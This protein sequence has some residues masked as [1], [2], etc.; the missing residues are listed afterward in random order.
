[1]GALPVRLDRQFWLRTPE[2]IF[3]HRTFP[4]RLVIGSRRSRPKA[5]SVIL[6]PG[7]AWS[8]L[9]SAW[10]SMRITLRT[11]SGSRPNSTIPCLPGESPLDHL[12][13]RAGNVTVSANLLF[14]EG[15][16]WFAANRITVALT[17]C[18]HPEG[19]MFK[20]LAILTAGA[21][22]VMWHPL[23]S[24]AAPPS[25]D[26][27]ADATPV[28]SLPF[29]DAINTTEAT[30]EPG[31]RSPS[32]ACTGTAYVGHSVW[33]KY[34][35]STAEVLAADT[36]GSTFDTVLA[37]YM[38]GVTETLLLETA[39]DAQGY[40]SEV[41][42]PAVPGTTYYFQITGW[43]ED[44]GDLRFNLR[45]GLSHSPPPNDHFADATLITD[46]PFYDDGNTTYA[47][48]ESGEPQPA[49]GVNADHSVWYEFTP[50]TTVTVDAD[51]FG[52]DFDTTLAAYTGSSLTS[53]TLVA[54]NDDSGSLQSR[55]SF[56]A[57]DGLSH[58]FQVSGWNG[59]A[60][61]LRFQLATGPPTPAPAPPPNDDFDDAIPITD[62]PFAHAADTNNAT[63]ETDEPDPVCAFSAGH[64]VWYEFTPTT[65]V[66]VDADTLGSNFDTVLAAYTGSGLDSLT[67]VTCNDDTGGAQSRVK[68]NAGGGVTYYFQITG[69][70]QHS[71]DLSF[72]LKTEDPLPPPS[73]DNFADATVITTL[74]IT[75]TVNTLGATMQD[76]EPQPSSSCTGGATVDHS[77]WYEFT[78]T[79][80]VTIG[81][82]TFGSKFDT[83][84]AVYTGSDLSSLTEV[85]CN[86]QWNGNQSRVILETSIGTTYYFQVSGWLGSWGDLV[87]AMSEL[88]R[89]SRFETKTYLVGNS[90]F[91]SCPGA[92]G[93]TPFGSSGGACFDLQGNELTAEVTITDVTDLPVG[94]FWRFHSSSGGALSS[95]TFCGSA[96]LEIP[97]DAAR[98]LVWTDGPLGPVHCSGTAVGIGT[99]G[100][101]EV[102]YQTLD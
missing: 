95:G 94:A 53:L 35:P 58:Y 97:V 28:T 9:Y 27:F 32:S 34:T 20:R 45:S 96:E 83:V 50:T 52:S 85:A 78:P 67:Q 86:D 57:Q 18:L 46:S 8:L 5:F 71:G 14:R 42:F 92:I 61:Y 82:D 15:I 88:V 101:I 65:T 39:C 99:T 41:S 102:N 74:P 69:Y 43:L 47:T 31:E 21:L 84:I 23:P 26:N 91:V 89:G 29:I 40:Q 13:P 70:G 11:V 48:M 6:I 55:V 76:G 54:C 81:A 75:S 49:C 7:G 19:E 51:T 1:M 30:I 22:F 17:R 62:T 2:G 73:N 10:S 79:T 38:P 66:T 56:N 4:Y 77:V 16:A 90:Q 68:F 60:G 98:L 25:N 36:F 93:D 64:S 24:S 80:T 72:G 12:S 37:V 44:S 63:L 59:S 87:F 3:D 100:T 33:Y